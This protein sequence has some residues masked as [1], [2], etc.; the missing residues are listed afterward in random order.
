MTAALKGN[1][2][3]S[4]A[5]QTGGIDAIQISASQ[6]TTITG[7]LTVN[8]A[9]SAPGVG[10][11][12]ILN[13][14]TTPGTWTKPA[15]LKAIKVTVVGGGAP[16][17]SP[18]SGSVGGSGGGGGGASIKYYSAPTLPGPQ[19]YTVGAVSSTSSF[20]VAPA[21]VI[22]AT[23][24]TTGA[25]GGLGSGGDTNIGGGPGQGF[26]QVGGAAGV[27]GN[28]GPS[29]LGGGGGGGS[30]TPGGGGAGAAGRVF[31]GGGGG[32]GVQAGVIGA[33]GAGAAG[34]IIV[35]EFY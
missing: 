25:A 19:P 23:G 4:G 13:S 29:I 11:N 33:A 12:Y 20:G 22:S 21:T 1:S 16:G 9:F 8:G 3:G 31:G 6:N 18:G 2:D 5:I 27:G 14:Y 28:G 30:S 17:S 26:L 32:G 34:V 24:G 15:G 10:G 35:E 7:S